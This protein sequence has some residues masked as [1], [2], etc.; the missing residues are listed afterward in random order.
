MNKFDFLPDYG[1]KF[2]ITL[3][4]IVTISLIVTQNRPDYKMQMLAALLMSKTH[5]LCQQPFKAI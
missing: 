5:T 3:N 1:N 2:P 4:V